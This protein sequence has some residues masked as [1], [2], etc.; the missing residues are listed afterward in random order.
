MTKEEIRLL[1]L[2]DELKQ[3]KAAWGKALDDAERKG[4]SIWN[5]PYHRAEADARYK[6]MRLETMYREAKAMY[7]NGE[8]VISDEEA[9]AIADFFFPGMGVNNKEELS[10][11][12][13]AWIDAV[14]S[15]F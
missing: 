8:G 12:D 6:V 13:E 5:D 3:A 2:E 7:N 4:T 11:E 14:V 1:A 15:Q 9:D 10:P